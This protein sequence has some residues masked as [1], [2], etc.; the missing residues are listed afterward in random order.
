MIKVGLFAV[1]KE[2]HNTETKQP[3]NAKIALSVVMRKLIMTLQSKLEQLDHPE[4]NKVTIRQKNRKNVGNALNS[5][6][7][8]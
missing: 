1:L 6:R 8:P 7:E 4:I 2:V 5:I 3:V